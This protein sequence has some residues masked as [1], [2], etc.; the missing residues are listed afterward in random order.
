MR[1][2][3]RPAL[4]DELCRVA[5]EALDCVASSTLLREHGSRSFLPVAAYGDARRFAQ[6]ADTAPAGLSATI[7]RL[8]TD[9][10]V[11]TEIPGEGH[12]VGGEPTRWLAIALRGVD[13]PCGILFVG[14]MG[15]ATPF[16]ATQRRIAEGISRIASIALENARLVEELERANRVKSD[17][18]ATMSHELRTPLHIMLGYLSLLA[19]GD[20][21][22]L[23]D[24]QREVLGLVDRN[25]HALLELVQDTLD[26]SRLE[27][28]SLP[29]HRREVQPADL[30]ESLRRDTE[31]LPREDAVSLRWRADEGLPTLLT[32][33]GKLKLALRNLVSNACKFTASGSVT[34]SAQL[35]GDGVEFSVA[36]TGIGIPPESFEKIFEP[37]TQLGA[38]TTRRYGGVGMGLYI[39]R[40]LTDLLGGTIGVTSRSGEGSTFNIWIPSMGFVANGTGHEAASPAASAE[41]SGGVLQ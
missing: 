2:L 23:S 15:A 11:E 37:F 34:V 41:S 12:A 28:E 25:A 38:T 22:P 17:F 4:I 33:A 40:R 19:D 35:C 9:D 39:A 6:L 5:A 31:R 20:F 32:D 16:S 8:G 14:R 36:D 18:V 10:V 13:G 24:S 1:T 3:A 27:R 29:L 21:G 7:A 26:L 30:L